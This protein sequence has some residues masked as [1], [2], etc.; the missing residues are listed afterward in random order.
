VAAIS[1]VPLPYR[2]DSCSYF[3]PMRHLD[4]AV[5]LDSARPHCASGRFDLMSALPA[6]MLESSGEHTRISD[7]D[8]SMLS[9]EDPFTL[10]EQALRKHMPEPRVISSEWPFTG[11]AIGCFG[12]G[13]GRRS[14]RLP[15]SPGFPL[16]AE[17]R[18]GIYQWALLQDHDRRQ[19]A[20]VF[21]DAIAAPQRQMLLGLLNTPD[22]SAS[23]PFLLESTFVSNLDREAYATAF[24]RVQRYILAGDCYQVNLAQR[25]TAACSGDPWQAYLLL[26]RRMASPYSAYLQTADSA[27]LSFSP[28]RFL[29]LADGR[30]ETRPIKGTARR[31]INPDADLQQASRLLASEKDR[32]ENIMIV[33]LMR[34]DLGKSCRTGSVRVEKLCGLE[35]YANV[36]HLVSVVTGQLRAG[37]SPFRLLA[38]CFPGGSITGAPKIRAMQIIDE[39]EPDPREIYCGSIGYVSAHGI[40]DT[41]IAIRTLVCHGG[42]VHAWGGGGIV[43]DSDCETEYR[44][45]LTKIEPLLNG[46]LECN[47]SAALRDRAGSRSGTLP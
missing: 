12:Y 28:E 24:E 27:V 2:S 3:A 38:D 35:S 18:V 14:A 7:H 32:A 44:E 41:S 33:D 6:C 26:R 8:G 29:H 4:G 9:D 13:L 16:L 34:N 21:S 36:H 47:A 42:E 25:L 45:S 15:R 11:G 39:L 30:V 46:L 1:I 19:C 31:L 20:V 37:R 5:F 40:M 23:A 22:T 17:L 10:L 43:A